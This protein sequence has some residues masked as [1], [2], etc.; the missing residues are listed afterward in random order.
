MTA[1]DNMTAVSH[2]TYA[3]VCVNDAGNMSNAS[4]VCMYVAGVSN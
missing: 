2:M 1:A 3:G 4:N